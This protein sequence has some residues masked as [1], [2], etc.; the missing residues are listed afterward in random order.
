MPKETLLIVNSFGPDRPGIVAA[1]LKVLLEYEIEIVDIELVSL[2][3]TLGMHLLL[4][5]KKT[6]KFQERV[7]KDLL[8][9][10]SKNNLTLTYQLVSEDKLHTVSSRKFMIL[11]HFGDTRS[12]A[13][14]SSLMGEEN[15]NIEFISSHSHHAARSFEMT[16][17]IA[18]HS[19][20]DRLKNRLMIKSRELDIDLAIQ[21]MAAYR[22]N[23]RMICFDMDSTLVSMEG[24]DE[25]ARKA[26]VHRE[27][28]RITEKAMRGD[29]DFEEAL[30]QRVAM[31]KG[32]A[33]DDVME[34]RNHLTL[35]G[36]AEE[37]LTTLKWL[38]FKLGIVSGGFDIFAD[39]LKDR[40][41]LDFAF[42]NQLD[43]KNG[44][45]TGK[46]NGEIVDAAR[47]AR[48][49]NQ[50]ACDLVIPLDQVVAIGDGANDA[51]MLSQA[52]L[53]IA[54]NAKKGLDRVA[55]AA[56]SEANFNHIFHLLG[57][58]EEDIQEAM[59]CKAP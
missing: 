41:N 51:L 28:A 35:S 45:L 12:V 44:A 24:I 58:A 40:F 18:A 47:K 54:Y 15:V 43:M 39:Y 26:G 46:L 56:L 59:S 52:G 37:L 2:Q 53:G 11:T 7:I 25:M 13:E 50:V 27:V 22:K 21:S 30:R 5:L 16:I 49:L 34:I 57:I 6:G 1:F 29:F 23:K 19:N 36:G 17:N 32:L 10:G 20:V 9:E 3:N 48:I 33:L 38:G 4:R 42:A 31:L 14:L 8:F 55:N